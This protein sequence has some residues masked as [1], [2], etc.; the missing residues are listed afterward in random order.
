MFRNEFLQ[1]IV[2]VLEQSACMPVRGM[3]RISMEANAIEVS[4]DSNPQKIGQSR[5]ADD[6]LPSTDF[7]L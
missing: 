5:E 1:M 2:I 7:S 6:A 3:V 4:L